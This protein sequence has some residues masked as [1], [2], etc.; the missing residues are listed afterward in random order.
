MDRLQQPMDDPITTALQNGII[1]TIL[2]EKPGLIG[3]SIPFMVSYWEGMRLAK[4]FKEKA[5]HIPIIIGGALIENHEAIF[6]GDPRLFELL[7]LSWS[8]ME[9]L[10]FPT[11][12]PLWKT[13]ATLKRCRTFTI[14]MKKETGRLQ[15]TND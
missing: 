6:T 8:E 5:P 7:I 15:F 11:L 9:T 12:P 3:I 2:T 10:H 1:D 14:K 4:L 13:A